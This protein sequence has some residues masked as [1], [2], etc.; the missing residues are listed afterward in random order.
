VAQSLGLTETKGGQ[1]ATP[2]WPTGQGLASFQ[3]P[4]S[5]RVNLSRQEGYPFIYI[6]CVSKYFDETATKVMNCGYVLV[7]YVCMLDK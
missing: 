5:T 7:H 6:L 1:R 4:S 3:N 2:P